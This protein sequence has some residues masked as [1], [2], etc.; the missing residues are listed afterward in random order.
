[1]KTR[2]QKGG[3]PAGSA[4]LAAVAKEEVSKGKAVDRLAALLGSA[5]L[6][7]RGFRGRS[8]PASFLD[9]VA[10]L[11]AEGMPHTPSTLKDQADKFGISLPALVA[12]I[13]GKDAEKLRAILARP[14]ARADAAMEEAFKGDDEEW[15]AEIEEWYG[16]PRFARRTLML[17]FESDDDERRAKIEEWYDQLPEWPHDRPKEVL[18]EWSFIEGEWLAE[19]PGKT[20]KPGEV[21]RWQEARQKASDAAR[22]SVSAKLKA[23]AKAANDRDITPPA[24]ECDEVAVALESFRRIQWGQRER[25]PTIDDVRVSTGMSRRELG[26]VLNGGRWKA[27]NVS[28][29]AGSKSP[30]GGRPAVKVSPVGMQRIIRAFLKKRKLPLDRAQKLLDFLGRVKF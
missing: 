25:W 8:V 16:R 18:P 4:A 6:V 15:R 22:V 28:R 3:I 9:E 23:K 11:V 21:F 20:P 7:K 19:H 14:N 29:G 2:R 13:R 30:R 5:V 17:D 24:L 27:R 26:R 10:A 1:M 12:A